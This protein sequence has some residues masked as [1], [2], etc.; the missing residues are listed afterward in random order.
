MLCLNC[1]NVNLNTKKIKINL[2]SPKMNKSKLLNLV[3]SVYKSIG[4]SESELNSISIDLEKMSY[5][6]LIKYIEFN[7]SNYFLI[8]SKRNLEYFIENNH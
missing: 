6:D 2:D 5:I 4:T 1:Y 7:F 8:Y 3:Y